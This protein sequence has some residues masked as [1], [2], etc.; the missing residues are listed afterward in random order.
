VLGNKKFPLTVKIDARRVNDAATGTVTVRNPSKQGV[1]VGTAS[2]LGQ[3]GKACFLCMDSSQH[4][5]G[6]HQ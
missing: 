3:S 6:T 4:R 1:L 5:A 2:A